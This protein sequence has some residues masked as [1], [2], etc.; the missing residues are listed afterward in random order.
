MTWIFVL[1]FTLPTFG[2]PVRVQFEFTSLDGCQRIQKVVLK[3]LAQ[4]AMQKFDLIE[5]YAYTP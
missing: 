4:N 3:E 2:G 5:C 1:L